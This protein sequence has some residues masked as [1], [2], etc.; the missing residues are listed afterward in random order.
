M[1]KVDIPTDFLNKTYLARC[2]FD[3]KYT[4]STPEGQISDFNIWSRALTRKEAEEWTSCRNS[5]KG[6]VVNWDKVNLELINMTKE[7]RNMNTLCVPPR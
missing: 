1:T 6:D 5:L 2:S 3:F 7:E 4:C